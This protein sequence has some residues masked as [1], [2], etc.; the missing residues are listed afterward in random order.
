MIKK[1]SKQKIEL[2]IGINL[3]HITDK[4]RITHFAKSENIKCLPSNNTDDMLNKFLNHFMKTVRKIL[5]FVI[6]AVVLY[7][8]ALK[9]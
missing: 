9:N 1:I 6:Q 4:K 7:M 8:K 2:D 3:I 5:N